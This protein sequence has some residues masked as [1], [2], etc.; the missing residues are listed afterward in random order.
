MKT[1]EIVK[2][3]GTLVRPFRVTDGRSFRMKDVDPRYARS[4]KKDRAKIEK[5]CKENIEL[6]TKLQEKLYAGSK[7]GVL[8]IFQ[9]RDAAGKD[10]AIK[11]VMSGINPQGCNVFSFKTPSKEE[12]AHDYM[13][14]CL[15]RSPR[16]GQIAIFNRSYYEEALVVRVHPELLQHQNLPEHLVTKEIW[17]H[18]FQDFRSHERFLMR[19]GIVVVKFYL[20]ISK[21]EQKKRFLERLDKPE[22]NWKFSAGDIKERKFWKEYENAYEQVIRHTA[23]PQAPWYAIPADK[24]WFARA[25]VSAAIVDALGSLNLGFPRTSTAR[26]QELARARRELMKPGT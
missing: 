1:K 17:Q 22:K 4:V 26:K 11:R 5:M 8:L 16:R 20:H 2:R 14:R 10:S 6:L 13:W 25:V 21:K 12:L 23:T 7:F 24:K 15:Q 9:A 18:R 3:A 19:Q